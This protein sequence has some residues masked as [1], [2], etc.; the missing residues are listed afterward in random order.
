MPIEQT[1][2][3][4]SQAAPQGVGTKPHTT[5]MAVWGVPAPVVM[6]SLFKVQVGVKC[7]STCKLTGQFVEV[8]EEGGSKIFEGRLG[9]SPRHGSSGLY[10]AEVSLPAPDTEGVSCWSVAFAGDKLGS[11]HQGAFATF[12]FRTAKPPEHGVKVEVTERDAGPI[13]GAEVF[14]GIYRASTDERG[15]ADLELPKGTYELNVRKP[16][17]ETPRVIVEVVRDVSV[18]IEA[19]RLPKGNPDEDQVWM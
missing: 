11:P 8:T 3:E 14:V 1:N 17:Y 18:G 12:S 5:S 2:V 7:S 13:A 6:D 15:L 19:S 10:V 4:M 16:G 9:E